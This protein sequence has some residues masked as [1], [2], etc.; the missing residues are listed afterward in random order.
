MKLTKFIKAER[1][2]MNHVEVTYKVSNGDEF[3]VTWCN[4]SETQFNVVE[5][6]DIGVLVRS[7]NSDLAERVS[8]A[9]REGESDENLDCEL[10]LEIRDTFDRTHAESFEC[11]DLEYEYNEYVVGYVVTDKTTGRSVNF[12]FSPIFSNHQTP[13][14]ALSCGCDGDDTHKAFNDEELEQIRN[15]LRSHADVDA[16]EDQISAIMYNDDAKEEFYDRLSRGGQIYLSDIS[17]LAK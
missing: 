16:V 3:T 10:Y 13:D 7:N 14:Y 2:S 12:Q 8:N 4:L 5:D 15:W 17:E 6:Y 9:I 1:T 11:L